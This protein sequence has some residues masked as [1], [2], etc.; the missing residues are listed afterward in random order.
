MVSLQAEITANDSLESVTTA[1]IRALPH[2]D[3]PTSGRFNYTFVQESVRVVCCVVLWVV[4]PCGCI[5]TFLT[6]TRLCGCVLQQA[7][8]KKKMVTRRCSCIIWPT[9][10][11]KNL[12]DLGIIFLVL[13]NAIV[14]PLQVAFEL[15]QA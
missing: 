2:N 5:H 14:L 8:T 15:Q 12:W 3:D 11:A 6:G 9:T 10:P 13:Y 1:V 4:L 7:L